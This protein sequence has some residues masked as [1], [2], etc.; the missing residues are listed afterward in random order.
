MK[1]FEKF[2]KSTF[3]KEWDKNEPSPRKFTVLYKGYPRLPAIKLPAVKKLH[4]PLGQA[5]TKRHSF[6][7]F[8]TNQ[9]LTSVQI[10]TLLNYSVGL[11][12][13]RNLSE[14]RF[15]PSAGARYPIETYLFIR[16]THYLEPALYHYYLRT[17]CLEKLY[18][19]EE[20]S[21]LDCFSQ[22][23]VKKAH[24]LIVLTALFDRN[25]VKYGNRGYRHVLAEAGHI[26][27]NIYLISAALK[28][29]CCAIGGYIDSKLNKLI[30]IDGLT[31][32]V[33]YVLAIGK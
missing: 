18:S 3:I 24:G 2:H 5:L 13:N 17:H 14:S 27:Q 7:E 11:K 16:D 10:S 15:Y 20:A 1:V 33:V 31:E 9:H 21:L 26:A 22:R 6:R 19:Y 12:K 29:H 4:V 25:T 28:I 30:D 8:N 32:T 23:W